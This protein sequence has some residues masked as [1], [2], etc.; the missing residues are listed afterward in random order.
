MKIWISAMALALSS[1]YAQAID[2]SAPGG[3]T[4]EVRQDPGGRVVVTSNH[5]RLE[6]DVANGGVLDTVTFPRGTGRNLLTRPFA[7]YVDQ[8]SDGNSPRTEFHMSRQGDTA[9]L[10][11][12]GAL[13]AAGRVAAP[14]RFETVWT[15]TP[16][17][18]KV[19]QTLRLDSDIRA[20]IV[21]IGA[22]SLRADID[23]C[24][25]RIGPGDMP[26]KASS[27]GTY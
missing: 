19:D 22:M 7:T 5:W 18:V 17:T 2:L 6:F 21:G 10:E 4:L 16:F 20:S 8:W 14:I 24:G 13:G 1:A 9:R 23:E 11:F 3:G 25:W 26:E 27:T 15:I 12:T